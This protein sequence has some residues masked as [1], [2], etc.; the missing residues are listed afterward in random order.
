VDVRRPRSTTRTCPVPEMHRARRHPASLLSSSVRTPL[1]NQLPPHFQLKTNAK[2]QERIK[3]RWDLLEHI[4]QIYADYGDG[5]KTYSCTFRANKKGGMN[6]PEFR[7]YALN[8]RHIFPDC[9]DI[10]GKRIML[11]VDSGPGRS[12]KEFLAWC[13]TGGIIVCPGVPNTAAVSQE[14]DQSCG[15]FKSGYYVSLA[16]LVEHRLKTASASGQPQMGAADYG[17][18]IFGGK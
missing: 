13:R 8:I 10:D 16:A 17:M 14:M 11:K 12:D 5:R 3:I 9:A 2:T 1:A 6:T 7:K 18:L 4:P 15:G